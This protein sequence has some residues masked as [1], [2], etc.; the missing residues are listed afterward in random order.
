MTQYLL[1]L[2]CSLG[3]FSLKFRFFFLTMTVPPVGLIKKKKKTGNQELNGEKLSA[4]IQEKLNLP[5]SAADSGGLR[6]I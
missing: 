2:A 5:F 3:G 1:N 4:G 6:K